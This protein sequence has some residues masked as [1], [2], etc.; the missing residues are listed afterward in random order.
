MMGRVLRWA[1]AG[2]VLQRLMP[3]STLREHLG[4]LPI[5]RCVRHP[6]STVRAVAAFRRAATASGIDG[7]IYD[8]GGPLEPLIRAVVA[9]LRTEVD[10]STIADIGDLPDEKGIAQIAVALEQIRWRAWQ[11]MGWAM[12]VLREPWVIRLAHPVR[13]VEFCRDLPPPKVDEF[14]MVCLRFQHPRFSEGQTWDGE[15]LVLRV[16]YDLG[17]AGGYVGSVQPRTSGGAHLSGILPGD[18][19]YFSLA[20]IDEVTQD[21]AAWGMSAPGDA[22]TE[23]AARGD[24]QRP[25]QPV[26][27][28]N[29]AAGTIE[30][31][32][33]ACCQPFEAP[34]VVPGW[35]CGQCRTYNGLQRSE[36]K[37]CLHER[38]GVAPGAN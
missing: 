4:P 1:R 19:I 5:R 32:T 37:F 20:H 14:V 12:I 29:A 8:Q 9:R 17:A 18:E 15:N 16:V 38:C 27:Q 28:R 23:A 34:G 33:P 26:S 11:Y 7:S 10:T 6:L 13:L 36:C 2:L 24:R 30:T 31:E 3:L 35:T 25:G 21:L 22:A